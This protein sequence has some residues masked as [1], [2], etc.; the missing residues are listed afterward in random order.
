MSLYLF[1][2]QGQCCHENGKYLDSS[3]TFQEHT[4]YIIGALHV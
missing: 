1:I 3:D 2:G 4:N